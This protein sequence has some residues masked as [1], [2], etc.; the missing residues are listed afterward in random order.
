VRSRPCAR[1]RRWVCWVCCVCARAG[2]VQMAA[3]TRRT[4]RRSLGSHV[5]R[6]AHACGAATRTRPFAV[7]GAAH[8][9]RRV[10]GAPAAW[11]AW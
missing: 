4:E 9:E 11:D 1:A 6:L 2:G 5:A 7:A 8:R 3:R 10:T